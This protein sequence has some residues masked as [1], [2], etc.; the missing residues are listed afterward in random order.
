M[1]SSIRIFAIA[2]LCISI[3]LIYAKR[4]KLQNRIVGGYSAVEKQFPHYISIRQNSDDSHF[5]GGTIINRQHVLTAAHCFHWLRTSSRFSRRIYGV[6]NKTRAIDR[7]IRLNFSKIIIH[8][9]FNRAAPKH[10][11]ALLRT[12]ERIYLY[13]FVKQITLP[14]Q[15]Y[16]EPGTMAI[17]AGWGLTEVRFI[18][19][20][21]LI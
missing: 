8:E 14:T 7:G 4:S 18:I 19:F 3:S 17:L 2:V 15:E 5:C 13:E 1:F 16:I 11:I 12:D 10:D 20:F 21:C 9:K 6:I